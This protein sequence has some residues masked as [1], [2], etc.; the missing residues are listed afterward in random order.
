[1]LE[2][3]EWLVP[4]SPTRGWIIETGMIAAA[5]IFVALRVR[6]R[7][8]QAEVLAFFSAVAAGAAITYP[9]TFAPL[10]FSVR[11][12]WALATIPLSPFVFALSTFVSYLLFKP[13]RRP[14]TS[15]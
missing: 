14:A 3:L 10:F 5:I 13:Q 8:D 4:K 9:I 6:S 7:T 11:G 1:V 2:L 12:E 15:G